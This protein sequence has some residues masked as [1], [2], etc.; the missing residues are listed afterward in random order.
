MVVLVNL[1]HV[2]R[3]K[4]GSFRFRRRYPKKVAEA[5]GKQFMQMR[6]KAQEGED[7][8]REQALLVLEFDRRVADAEDKA[9]GI[10][11]QSPRKRWEESL[12]ETAHMAHGVLG[13]EDAIERRELLAESLHMSG[14]DPMLV[15]AAAMP[16]AAP[17]PITLLDAKNDYLKL[18]VGS[19]KKSGQK[20]D[21]VMRRVAKFWG[22]LDEVVLSDLT[23]EKARFLLDAMLNDTLKSGARLSPSTVK[24]EIRLLSAMINVGLAEHDLLTTVANPLKGIQMPKDIET[25]ASEARL[26]LPE[27]I[28]KGMRKRLKENVRTP[29][30]GHLWEIL[31]GT[32]CR[33]AE[34]TGLTM[35]DVRLDASIPHIDIRPNDIRQLKTQASVRQVPLVGLALEATKEAVEA[36]S[37]VHVATGSSPSIVPSV[38]RIRTP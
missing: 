16:Q 24:R 32:G 2:D 19:D 31:V 4:D 7:L 1:K 13:A 10:T 18:N 28:V 20:V 17:P 5:L 26:P 14:A 38:G 29:V 15:R 33:L 22:P 30:Q 23:K 12:R 21:R 9:M 8:V 35:A 36:R 3:L 11:G 34:V 6:M 25:R 37:S 27:N